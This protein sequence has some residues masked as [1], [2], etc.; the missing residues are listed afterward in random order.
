MSDIPVGQGIVVSYSNR[1]R[2]HFVDLNCI[3]PKA[4]ENLGILDSVDILLDMQGGYPPGKRNESI[5]NHRYLNRLVGEE[6]MEEGHL[7]P[8]I[9]KAVALTVCRSFLLV[10]P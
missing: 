7:G 3:E 4:L 10:P 9:L 8:S 2:V 1:L 5:E 6:N